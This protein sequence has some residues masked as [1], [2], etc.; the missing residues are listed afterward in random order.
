M[1]A[2][3][4]HHFVSQCY[5]RN[6]KDENELLYIYDKGLK[7]VFSNSGTKRIFSKN[8]L[9]TIIIDGSFSYQIEEDFNVEFENDYTSHYNNIVRSVNG[10]EIDNI[11]ESILYACR[12]GSVGEQRNSDFRQKSEQVLYD[13]YE[14][15]LE[16]ATPELQKEWN[17]DKIEK[18]DLPYKV[19][20]NYKE[21]ADSIFRKIGRIGCRVFTLPED[22]FFLFSDCTAITFKGRIIDHFN[23][24][25]LEIAEIGMPINSNT[26]IHIY[27]KELNYKPVFDFQE[28]NDERLNFINTETYRFSKKWVACVNQDYLKIFVASQQVL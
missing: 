18:I 14:N 16:H 13:V 24:K 1:S 11:T 5:I 3:I 27:S 7:N 17:D 12:L 19:P 9:N 21:I 22:R 23:P 4:N 26:F 2:Q 6:F 20:L 28:M 8:H 10:E 15:L 25:A